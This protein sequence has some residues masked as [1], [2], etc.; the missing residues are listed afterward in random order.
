MMLS[1]INF[2]MAAI[3]FYIIISRAVNHKQ[4]AFFHHFDE[5]L[6]VLATPPLSVY[7]TVK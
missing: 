6:V 5:N 1:R 2:E 7:Q 4:I 3:I